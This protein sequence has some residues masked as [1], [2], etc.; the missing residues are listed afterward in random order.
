MSKKKPIKREGFVFYR[1]FYEAI[2]L[3]PKEERLEVLETVLE[4]GLNG[5]EKTLKNIPRAIW[6]LIRPQI[7]S[8]N[9]RYINGLKGGF[10][11]KA[12]PKSNLSRT[13]ATP[14]EKEKEKEKEKDKDKEKIA[15]SVTSLPSPKE[16]D[17]FFV[18]ECFCIKKE[19]SEIW[20]DKFSG[21][22]SETLLG[23][24]KTVDEYYQ[25][26]DKLPKNVFFAVSSWVERDQPKPLF[27]K[28]KI[29]LW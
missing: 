26:V 27:A 16:L 18:G 25:G 10:G 29:V 22:T 17:Y 13:K 20:I 9:R 21:Y 19:Q 7:D 14:K 1:S 4:Y 5:V 2:N 12:E 15:N 24:L 28:D 3:L 6:V 23:K 11:T 8:N